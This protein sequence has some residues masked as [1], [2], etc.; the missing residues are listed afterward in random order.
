VA[1]KAGFANVRNTPDLISSKLAALHFYQLAIPAPA[2]KAGSFDS[3]AAKRGEAVFTGQARCAQCH[4]PP[5]FTEPGWNMHT[6]EEIGVD[7]FQ[8]DRSP[9]RRYRTTPLRGLSTH[10]KGGFYHDGRF[11]TL[12]DVVNHYDKH[13]NLKLTPEQKHDLVEYLKSL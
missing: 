9:D 5:L 12:D 6:P 7:S 3:D 4:V 1:V 2:P 10:M 8:A 13:F 11:G